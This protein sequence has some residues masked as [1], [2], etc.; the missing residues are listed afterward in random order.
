ME[1]SYQ[2]FLAIGGILL[3]G[4]AV[5]I[6]CYV[7]V[8]EEKFSKLWRWG[9]NRRQFYLHLATCSAVL[10]TVIWTFGDLF[11]K[12]FWLPNTSCIG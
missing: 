3:V 6:Q 4:V 2:F 7:E 5:V 12:I 10:G 1:F 9:L 11:P 8:N